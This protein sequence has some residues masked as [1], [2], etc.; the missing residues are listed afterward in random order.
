MMICN[1]CQIE[2]LEKDF[3]WH[4]KNVKRYKYC[5]K[6]YGFW[7]LL[8]G[9]RCIVCDEPSGNKY[10][11]HDCQ[12][13]KL[14]LDYIELW[15][16]GEK[17]GRKGK[18]ISKYVRHYLFE[19]YDNK[20]SKCGW[21]EINLVTNKIPLEVE[22]IDG[23]FMNNVP[24]NLTLLCPNCHSLTSTFGYLNAGNGRKS[25]SELRDC[26]IKGENNPSSILTIEKVR[27]IRLQ[28]DA[29]ISNRDLSREYNVDPTTIAAIIQGKT[30]AWLI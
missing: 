14:Y 1:R 17:S 19:K 7:S 16:K 21:G 4:I 24:D 29:G 26:N 10:C 13:R 12:N 18:Y 11:S 2:K 25:R 3:Y 9:N 5:K 27:T 8:K 23:N 20:C 15:H 22:H 28:H 30:W 6:C